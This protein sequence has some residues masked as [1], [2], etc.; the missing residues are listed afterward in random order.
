ME[1]VIS[2]Y[3]EHSDDE[4]L[5]RGWGLLELARSK[6][7]VLRHLPV[8]GSTI[9]DVGGG[10]GVYT[11][12]L[13]ELGYEAHLIDITPVHISFAGSNRTRIASQKSVTPGISHGLTNLSTPCC[14]WALSIT[15]PRPPNGHSPY[16]KLV[17]YCALAASSS[18]RRSADSHRCLPHWLATSL[19]IS[20]FPEFSRATFRMGSTGI[21]PAIQSVSPRRTSIA[22]RNWSRTSEPQALTYS[23]S[24]PW[25]VHAG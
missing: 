2:F 12:W 19:T 20:P 24:C 17:G 4:R 5:S 7:I 14:S 11:E 9:L 25:K 10:T 18:L 15:S 6:E 8:S 1:D 13:G 22:R 3:S 23:T 16:E 21:Q